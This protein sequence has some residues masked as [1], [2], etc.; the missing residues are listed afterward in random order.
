MHMAAGQNAGV[1]D[2]CLLAAGRL[3][4]SS[5][6]VNAYSPFRRAVGLCAC[7]I[8]SGVVHELIYW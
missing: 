1:A 2:I 6:A 4:R 3:V 8:V 5:R 7:F